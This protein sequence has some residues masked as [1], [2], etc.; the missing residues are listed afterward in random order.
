MRTFEMKF[1]IQSKGSMMIQ[2]ESQEQ[3]EKLFKVIRQFMEW[4]DPETVVSQVS[5]EEVFDDETADFPET[6]D[7][8]G[9]PEV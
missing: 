7:F 6:L 1:T 9:L 4:E 3:A 2:S 8:T 5:V